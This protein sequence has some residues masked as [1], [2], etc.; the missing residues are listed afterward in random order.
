MGLWGMFTSKP[1]QASG[2]C[3]MI[4]FLSDL[5]TCFNVCAARNHHKRVIHWEALFEKDVPFNSDIIV[6]KNNTV[7][8]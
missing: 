2:H 4:P 7:S 5:N 1:Q 6:Y 3:I 8:D